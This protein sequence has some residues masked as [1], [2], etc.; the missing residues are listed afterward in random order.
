MNLGTIRLLPLARVLWFLCASAA[1]GQ[2]LEYFNHAMHTHMGD[3]EEGFQNPSAPARSDGL[4]ATLSSATNQIGWAH[5]TLPLPGATRLSWNNANWYETRLSSLSLSSR[6]GK[7]DTAPGFIAGV[8]VKWDGEGAVLYD[9]GISWRTRL[10]NGGM[11]EIGAYTFALFGER[12]TRLVE[13]YSWNDMTVTQRE[14]VIQGA[15]QSPSGFWEA[16]GSLELF[17][18]ARLSPGYYR[19]AYPIR[20]LEAGIRPVPWFK[21]GVK[22]ID[23]GIREY[24]FEGSWKRRRTLANAIRFRVS[25]YRDYQGYSAVFAKLTCSFFGNWGQ[26]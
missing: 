22:Q 13:Y 21:L 11:L 25:G 6:F 19:Y 7:S 20:H 24:H 23:D 17:T 8:G 14:A 16:G 18:T 12:E 1:V 5:A 2:N 15:W 4:S 9:P 3:P 26:P 10:G